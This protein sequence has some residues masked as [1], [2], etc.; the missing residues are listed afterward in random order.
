MNITL[1]VTPDMER[2]LKQ[3]ARQ[4]GLT[5]DSYVVELL[6]QDLRTRAAPERLSPVETELLQ[7]I[8]ASLSAI[9]WERYRA[10]LAKRDAET[11]N[12]EEQA[13]LIALSDQI[14]NANVR[15][16]EAVAKLARVRKTTVAE[17]MVTLG[18]SPAYA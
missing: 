17:L 16:M 7:R 6:K 11:V 3:A 5:P 18:L 1:N 13:E 8:N 14:E 10:L 15:R 2:Q 12:A 9:E 4:I